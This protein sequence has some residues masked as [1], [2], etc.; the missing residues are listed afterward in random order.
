MSTIRT[1]ETIVEEITINA[2]AGRIFEALTDPKQCIKWW[3]REGQY[4]WTAVESDLRTGGRLV[5]RG[6]GYGGKTVTVTGV[7]RE[8]ERPRL[9]VHTWL[10][11]WQGDATESVVR[12]DLEERGDVTTV[13]ITHSGLSTE[14]SRLSHRGWPAILSWLQEYTERSPRV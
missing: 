1:E 3:G 4:G 5:M 10:P 14:T 9:L 2:P 8:I 6:Y 13:R 12:W 7:Y 11:D